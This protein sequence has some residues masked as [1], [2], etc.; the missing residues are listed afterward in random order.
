M[1]ISTKYTHA[2]LVAIPYDGKRREIVDGE[3]LVTPSPNL[4]HQAIARRITFAFMQ[5]LQAHPTGE[6]FFAPL[7]VILSDLDVL[8]PDLLFVLNERRHVLQ[9]WVRGAPDLVVEIL[10]PTTAANDRGPKLK[11]YAR[12]GVPECWIV[13]PDRKA[14]EVY[15][16]SPEGYRLAET[17]TSD[18]KLSS[19]LLPGLELSVKDIFLE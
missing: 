4:R 10:S 3:L 11:A 2:D 12:H 8:E 17:F 6:V 16:K 15:R 9:D 18:Q 7:D 5:Y 14:I 1:V 13:D 19:M